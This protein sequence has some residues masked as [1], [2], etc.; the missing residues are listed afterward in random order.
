MLYG[1]LNICG[2][3]GGLN[4]RLLDVD[5]QIVMWQ[6]WDLNLWLVRHYAIAGCGSLMVWWLAHSGLNRKV[7][8]S[9]PSTDI[10]LF[11]CLM[12]HYT[13]YIYRDSVRG[14]NPRVLVFKGARAWDFNLFLVLKKYEEWQ[15][16]VKKHIK[17]RWP[18]PF[19]FDIY[20]VLKGGPRFHICLGP[21]MKKI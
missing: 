11:D 17:Y 21:G 6:C 19:W 13:I 18:G 12:L 16:M 15:I 7:E 20:I 10:L 8:G 3:L 5:N 14:Q 9:I 1:R 4:P 2:L